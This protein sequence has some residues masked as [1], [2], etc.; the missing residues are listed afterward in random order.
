MPKVLIHPNHLE[1]DGK[2]IERNAVV[3]FIKAKK[4]WLHKTLKTREGYAWVVYNDIENSKK[5]PPYAQQEMRSL[6]DYAV[7]LCVAQLY[8][9]GEYYSRAQTM[10]TD[11][12]A[13]KLM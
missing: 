2:K 5:Y 12:V 13:F 8:A 10:V 7:W 1:L 3:Q 9:R 6:L 4:S 11:E